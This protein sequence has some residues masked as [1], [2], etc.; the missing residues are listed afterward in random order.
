MFFTL[1]EQRLR[2]SENGGEEGIW[3]LEVASSRMLEK[4]ALRGLCSLYLSAGVT[5]VIKSRRMGWAVPFVHVE[6]RN[7]CRVL[8]GRP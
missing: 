3:T 4:T 5:G 6:K 8:V 2:V 7:G 1:E